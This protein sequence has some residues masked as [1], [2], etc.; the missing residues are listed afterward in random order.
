[1]PAKS[2]KLTYFNAK[3]RAELA[4]LVLAQAG[5]E[6]EDVRLEREEWLNVKPSKSYFQFK[7]GLQRGLHRLL[8]HSDALVQHYCNK[9]YI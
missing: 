6:F 5:A 7:Y 1:M 3:G 4:R 2:I 9:R 8:R